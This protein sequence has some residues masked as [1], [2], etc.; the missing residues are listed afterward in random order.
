MQTTPTDAKGST[1]DHPVLPPGHVRAHGH[2][3]R[4]TG[5]KN[6]LERNLSAGEVRQDLIAQFGPSAAFWM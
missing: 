3:W 6:I 5:R 4:E 1:D 2:V